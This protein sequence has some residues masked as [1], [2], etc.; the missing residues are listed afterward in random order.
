MEKLRGPFGEKIT[1]DHS[2]SKRILSLKNATFFVDS[3]FK[4]K[5]NFL[6]S[7][8]VIYLKAG[9]DLK[10]F[11]T[12]ED[13]V[14]K[15][16]KSGHKKKDPI[17]CIGGG[18]LGDSIGFLASVYLRGVP[19]Y[20]IPTTLL[21]VIDSSVGGKTALN[22]KN[23]KNQVGSFY[24]PEEIFIAKKLIKTSKLKDAKGEVLKTLALNINKKWA[25][26]QLKSLDSLE[27]KHFIKYKTSIVKKDIKDSKGKRVVLNL[28]HTLAHALELEFGVS[29]SVAVE[30]GL[31]FA[32]N[33]SFKKKLLSLKNL[34]LLYHNISS[35]DFKF[36]NKKKLEK[37][38]HSD[39]KSAGS[40][41]NFVFLTDK[42][43]VVSA[44]E[45]KSIVEEY[46]RQV[47]ENEL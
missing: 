37:Y 34:N 25:K 45:I 44:V 20:Q 38:L 42:G 31:V 39:K 46:F 27:L 15:L 2:I 12:I 16:I 6:K 28:G 14:L 32:L 9:E 47:K 26:E 11:K 41:I 7:S 18:S 33:W 30:A 22:F 21:A 3:F 4:G 43:P 1:I 13:L 10:S 19:F 36:K 24:A 17:I 5:I 8:N 29:H 35:I 40:K 23:Y